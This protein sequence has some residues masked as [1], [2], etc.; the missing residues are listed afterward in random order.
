MVG[1]IKSDILPGFP[2]AVID[3]KTI[4]GLDYIKEEGGVLKLGPLTR[5]VDVA[6]SAIVKNGYPALAKAYLTTAHPQIRNVARVGGNLAQRVRCWYYRFP[7]SMGGRILC[8]RKGGAL[9][10][11]VP[12]EN[13]YH[14]ILAGQVCFAV[15][16]SDAATAL[17]SLGATIVTN[18]RSIP[19]NDFYIVLGNTLA[20][21]EII[22]E[23]QVPTP[24]VGTKQTYTKMALRKAIDWA[25]VSVASAITVEGGTVT[26]AKITLGGVAPIPFRA[27]GAE[28]A[29]KGK[30][31]SETL[32]ATAGN[33]AVADAFPLTSNAYK[34][35]IARTLVRRAILS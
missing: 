20:T 6:E 24:K 30:A 13:R 33:A 16:P 14:S 2:E 19:L 7:H 32:A 22:T 23:V 29:I 28:D 1:V 4:P 5:L 27:T 17:S 9:C 35:Q 3:I 15:C 21:D 12:G 34:V 18:K 25:L 8:F 10:F 26:G 31:I 11:A